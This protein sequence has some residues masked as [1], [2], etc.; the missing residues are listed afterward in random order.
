MKAIFKNENVYVFVKNK[1]IRD[2]V[3]LDN[4]E[5]L[6]LCDK[7]IKDKNVLYGGRVSLE[8]SHSYGSY[9]NSCHIKI[10]GIDIAKYY[11]NPSGE[12]EA[13]F[14]LGADIVIAYLNQMENLGVD[15]FLENYKLQLQEL[16]KELESIAEN[17]QQ[18]LDINY[19]EKKASLLDSLK[20][21]IMKMNGVIFSLLINMNA[22]LQN[23]DYTNAYD[24]IINLY[25]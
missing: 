9:N 13:T 21:F 10:D 16:K 8:W 24:T 3:S 11:F 4:L 15:S 20:I 22:G 25:F 23:H 14:E 7:K 5:N 12:A 2:D 18:K 19:D 17:M 6:I 1:S